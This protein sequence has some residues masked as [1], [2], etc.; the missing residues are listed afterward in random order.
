MQTGGSKG[1]AF[2]EFDC[3]EVAKIVAETMNNYLMGERII[4]C[5]YPS[6]PRSPMP[7]AAE[8]ML[9]PLSTPPQPGHVMPPE[10]VHEKLFDGSC[11]EFKK[12]QYPAV[13]RYNKRPTDEE[14]TKTTKKL[15]QKEGKLRKR[16]A[17]HGIDYDFPG[18]V[19]E[20]RWTQ[21]PSLTFT[22][23]LQLMIIVAVD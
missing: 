13:K 10:K 1:Y 17:A 2:I 5:E 23:G 20:T 11:R 7:F 8:Q 16:L 9:T 15:L 6:A 3:V 4:K 22:S 21:C 14:I 19:R 18:F 12:P